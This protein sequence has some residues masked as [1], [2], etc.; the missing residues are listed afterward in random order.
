[1]KHMIKRGKWYA[2]FHPVFNIDPLVFEALVMN[3]NAMQSL[4]RGYTI[5][6]NA[7]QPI[8]VIMRGPF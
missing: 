6:L 2:R 3:T 5:I 7:G 4:R 8:L 1:M